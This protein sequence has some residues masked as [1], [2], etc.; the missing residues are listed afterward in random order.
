MAETK[1]E[2]KEKARKAEADE[3]AGGGVAVADEASA[4]ERAA[5]K[6]YM[7]SLKRKYREEVV[8][9]MVKRFGYKNINEVPRLEKI[10]V[11]MG[12]GEAARDAK[13]IDSA[14]KELATI[15]GQ[16]PNLTLARKSISAFKLREGSPVGAFVTLRGNMMYEFLERLI[17]VA[18]PRIRD[19]RGF[20]TRS[21]DGRGNHSLG[22]REHLIFMELDFNKVTA[23]KGM[24]ITTVTTAKT[25]EEALEL[26]RLF[27]FPFREK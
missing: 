12:V 6:D 17:S 27:G 21:F 26:L 9:A 20:P 22:I 1:Q 18:I 15:T 4:E 8:P 10:V 13:L 7:P 25:D 5:L 2:K 11:N 24:N 14:E 19:F 3:A 16:K 23:V